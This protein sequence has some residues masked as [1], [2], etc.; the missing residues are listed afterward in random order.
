VT[1]QALLALYLA[2][3]FA[4]AALVYVRAEPRNA[5]AVLSACAAFVVGPLWVPFV[6]TPKPAPRLGPFAARIAH[7]LDGASGRAG[8]SRL[9]VESMLRRVELAERRLRELEERLRVTRAL[10][11]ADSLRPADTA[12]REQAR[13]ASITRLE[14][15]RDREQRALGQL[16]ELCELL[17]NQH[18]L[19]RLDVSDRAEELQGELWVRIQALSE[20]PAE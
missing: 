1:A 10:A 2:A 14:A 18:V 11:P 7:A 13:N 15:A 5:A 12:A 6:L 8:F 9:E 3:G 4:F 17:E 19:A 16:A 20:L